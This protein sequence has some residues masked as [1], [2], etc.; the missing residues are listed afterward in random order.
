M[1][2]IFISGMQRSGTTAVEAL[3]NAHPNAFITHELNW[4]HILQSINGALFHPRH[5]HRKVLPYNGN[6]N[7]IIETL[8]CGSTT[9]EITHIG[10][11]LPDYTSHFDTLSHWFPQAKHIACIRSPYDIIDSMLRRN[12]DADIGRDRGWDEHLDLESMCAKWNSSMQNIMNFQEI[13]P[14]LLIV[15]YEDMVKDPKTNLAKLEE[16]TGLQGLDITKI[17]ASEA[18]REH[19]TPRIKRKITEACGNLMRAN[20]YHE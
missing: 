16:I 6:Y 18:H 12:Y 17:K 4:M 3:L 1:D 10:D 15:R 14:N 13:A 9:K 11:K 8:Y 5:T 2:I 19:I 7:S 20:D